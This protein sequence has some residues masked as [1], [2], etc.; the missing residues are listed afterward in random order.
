MSRRWD[1]PTCLV[2]G[3][4]LSSEILAITDHKED[5]LLT[6]V[7]S[8]NDWVNRAALESDERILAHVYAGKIIHWFEEKSPRTVV[9][10]F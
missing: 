5:F 8:W 1:S 10:G 2:C 4:L 6:D 3:G 7:S 9:F